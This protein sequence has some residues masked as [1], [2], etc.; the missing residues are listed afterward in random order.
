L[1]TVRGNEITGGSRYDKYPGVTAFL[2]TGSVS[3]ISIKDN[4]T[5]SFQKFSN[6]RTDPDLRISVE[7]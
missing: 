7:Q 1:P 5:K 6:L 4:T 2:F 3:D